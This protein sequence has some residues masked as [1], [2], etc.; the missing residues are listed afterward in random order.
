MAPL[1]LVQI[2]PTSQQTLIVHGLH[3]QALRGVAQHFGRGLRCPVTLQIKNDVGAE[4]DHI[5]HG[6]RRT[7]YHEINIG[8]FACLVPRTLAG[9]G[10]L[11]RPRYEPAPPSA[12]DCFIVP[13]LLHELAH[14]YQDEQLSPKQQRYLDSTAKIPGLDRAWMRYHFDWSEQQSESFAYRWTVAAVVWYRALSKW[15]ESK[16]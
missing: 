15:Y 1:A 16:A 9:P 7:G 11:R 6:N 2:P 5:L 12:V 14:C 3:P 13:A 4:A 10:H 8:L